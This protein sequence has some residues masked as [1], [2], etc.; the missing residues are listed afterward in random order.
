[1]KPVKAAKL[2]GTASSAGNRR[3]TRV[4]KS[5]IKA[6][7]A[8]AARYKQLRRLGVATPQMVQAA[9]ATSMLYGVDCQGISDSM[10]S[11]IHI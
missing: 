7:A 2:L 5:R 3:C 1:M 11:L 8:K 4:I 9:G 10:L 6:F